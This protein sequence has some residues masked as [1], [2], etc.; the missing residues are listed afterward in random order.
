VGGAII[1]KIIV[2][3]VP[4]ASGGALSILKDFYE[5]VKTSTNTTEWI[6]VVSTDQIKSTENIKVL[7][8]SWI[9]KSKLHR[10]LFDYVTAPYLVRKIKAD[11]IFSLQ[12][13]TVPFTGV[14]QIL[15]IHNALPFTNKKMKFKEDKSAWV[16]QNV[17]GRKIIS[18]AKKADRIIVQNNWMKEKCKIIT[19]KKDEDIEVVAPGIAG[20]LPDEYFTPDLESLPTF[21]YPAGVGVYKNHTLILEACRELKKIINKDFKVLFTLTGKENAYAKDLYD[22]TQKENL[23]IHFAGAMSREDVYSQYQKSILLFPSY[24]ES[25]GLPLLEARMYRCII[26]ASA[27]EFAYE[28]LSDYDNAY[29]FD[30]SE[31]DE[32]VKLMAGVIENKISYTDSSPAVLLPKE[33]KL[34]DV[35]S[36]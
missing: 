15:Y 8:Y 6:F 36:G 18:S 10:L 35:L 19:N 26:F 7:N 31:P 21:F 17:I 33:K 1:M 2:Y 27:C 14:K 3:D 9:K 25:F 24:I 20:V 32:L 23:P 12:N 5:E 13:V 4:A 22:E 16:Y 11:K 29:Y 30:Y 34:T 28:I